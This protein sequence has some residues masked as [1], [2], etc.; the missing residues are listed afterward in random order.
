MAVNNWLS[1]LKTVPWADVIANAPTVAE[2]AKKL[3]RG[4]AKDAGPVPAAEQAPVAPPID[5][6][7]AL[8]SRVE[9]AEGT[10][11]SLHAQMVESSR[12]L[13]DLAAQNNNLIA[14]VE[15]DRQR[16]LQLACVTGVSVV[17]SLVSL[18]FALRAA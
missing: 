11:T 4:A 17:L 6:V 3:W 15:A 16:L 8:T 2:G 10:V 18:Y 7:A 5:P 12:L 13:S 14:R 1:L 9:A